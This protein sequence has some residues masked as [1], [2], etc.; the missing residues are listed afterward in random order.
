MVHLVSVGEIPDVKKFDWIDIE[1]ASFGLT[2]YTGNLPSPMIPETLT[3]PIIE[4]IVKINLRS[5]S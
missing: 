1:G 3:P 5:D 2:N 4:M